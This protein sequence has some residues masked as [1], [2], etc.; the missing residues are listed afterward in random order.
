M[1]LCGNN[2]GAL[3]DVINRMPFWSGEAELLF[4]AEIYKESI[5]AVMTLH[6][7]C[8]LVL[9]PQ[10]II[11]KLTYCFSPGPFQAFLLLSALHPV[12]LS[13]CLFN[14]LP[15]HFRNSRYYLSSYSSLYFETS[16]DKYFQHT[17]S[18]KRLPE[19]ILLLGVSGQE[20]QS[21]SKA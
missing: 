21:C 10:A 11:S 6:F 13:V 8:N 2:S 17:F 15:V 7:L 4:V 19:K 12:H 1:L 20:L 18:S 5:S 16:F 3:S 9:L 14:P